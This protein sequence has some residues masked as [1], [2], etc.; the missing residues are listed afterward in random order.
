M[1]VGELVPRRDQLACAGGAANDELVLGPVGLCFGKRVAARFPRSE[2][3]IA[4]SAGRLSRRLFRHLRRGLWHR[5]I[6]SR[7][8]PQPVHRP[9][10]AAAE[11]RQHPRPL[12]GRFPFEDPL[13][14]SPRAVGCRITVEVHAP[15]HGSIVAEV[16]GSR[17][18]PPSGRLRSRRR[19][20]SLEIGRPRSQAQ[21]PRSPAG[22][23]TFRFW[24]DFAIATS[25]LCSC[26]PSSSRRSSGTS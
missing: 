22:F 26:Q 10:G 9:D 5:S 23:A 21:D 13:H 1:G 6:R 3:L 17:H 18:F 11:R 20:P 8:L 14:V 7:S 25:A 4:N 12:A 2:L 19:E 24:H 16:R 15:A